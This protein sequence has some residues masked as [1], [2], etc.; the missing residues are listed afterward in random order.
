MLGSDD[1]SPPRTMPGTTITTAGTASYAIT[2][3][4]PADQPRR[5]RHQDLPRCPRRAPP[6]A[7][8][9][10]PAI[11]AAARQLARRDL[12]AFYITTARLKPL[13]EQQLGR[14]SRVAQLLV[15]Q[16]ANL[17]AWV[18]GY[19]QVASDHLTHRRQRPARGRRH[20]AVGPGDGPCGA[21][22]GR[23]RCCTSRCATWA[24]SIDGLLA[25]VKTQLAADPKNT[26]TITGVE[27][28]FGARWTSCS[29]SSQDGA[30]GVVVRWPAACRRASSRRSATRRSAVAAS[31][32]LLGLLAARR[33]RGATRRSRCRARRERGHRDHHHAPAVRR[34]SRRTCR[35]SRP[36]ASRSTDGHLYLGLGDFAATAIAQ[37]PATSLATDPRYSAAVTEAG[38][39]QRGCRLGR[40][41]SRRAARWR[42]MTD[43]ADDPNYE[44][45][46]KPWVD[47]LD[48]LRV[49]RHRGR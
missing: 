36:S 42:S 6:P 16:L 35:S 32:L 43:A 26:E 11:Q 33:R 30:V 39:A 38:H 17:P 41:R 19:A 44:T 22:P 37:D 3:S 31:R 28:Q 20:G 5:R 2:D 1:R 10:T 7:S 47:A 34:A 12:G 27:Q 40:C 8:P 29:T 14:R 4:V 9:T 46:I 18:G 45:N 21:L 25:Q 13:I 49:D 48:Y 24:R 15:G 23:T